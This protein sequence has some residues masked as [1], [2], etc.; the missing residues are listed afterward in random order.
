MG[1][2]RYCAKDG[3]CHP[4]FTTEVDCGK[5]GVLDSAL[6]VNASSY[7]VENTEFGNREV[8]FS[9][10]EMDAKHPKGCYLDLDTSRVYFNVHPTGAE[11][12]Y[13][14]YRTVC[15]VASCV[16]TDNGRTNQHGQDCEHYKIY[17]WDCLDL[18]W[19][20]FVAKEMCCACGGGQEPTK[21]KP[22]CVQS[23]DINYCIAKV[24]SP[25]QYDQS[26]GEYNVYSACCERSGKPRNCKR[27]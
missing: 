21:F 8:V 3:R 13:E 27:R 10:S 11:A 23:G 4:R 24:A 19:R 1:R 15:D 9:M 2:S 20:D 25:Y 22:S 14:K 18:D 7:L 17:P 6:C 12:E 5:Y 26:V 16:N